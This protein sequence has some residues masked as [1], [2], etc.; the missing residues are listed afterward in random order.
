MA[1]LEVEKCLPGIEA[2]FA[3][4]S[5][6]LKK[7]IRKIFQKIFREIFREIFQVI[8]REIFRHVFPGRCSPSNGGSS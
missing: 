2:I 5:F 3:E 1:S 6:A 7:I 8:F 4:P